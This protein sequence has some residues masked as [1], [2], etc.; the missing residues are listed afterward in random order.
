[1]F[2]HSD[3][4]T[5]NQDQNYI[6][7]TLNE[8]EEEQSQSLYNTQLQPHTVLLKD[9]ETTATMY[10]IPAYPELLPKGLLA[11]LL[12]EFN[13][14]IEK[15]DSFPYYDMLNL[16]EFEKVWFHEGG[17]VCIMVLGEIPELDYSLDD[18]ELSELDINKDNH[19]DEIETMR[20]TAQY[21]KRKERRNINLNIQWEKQCL[22]IFSLQPAYPGRSSHVVTGSFLVNAGI[23]GKGIGKTLVETFV[24]WSKRLGFTSCCFPLIYGTNVGIRRILEVLNF[25]RIGKL[26]E[27]GILKGF[28]VPVDSFIYGKE[29]THITKSID[30]L[31]DPQQ[32]NDIAKYERLRYYLETGKYPP[33]CD[34]NE[35]ARLRVSSKTHSLQNG[36]LTTKGREIIYEPEQQKQIALEMHIV[37]HQGINKITSRIVERYHWK[38]IK[39]T[40]S[41]VIAQCPKCK[42]RHQDGT[43]VIVMPSENVRQAH[44]LPQ[45]HGE[46]N[47]DTY[48]TSTLSQMAA[49]VVR[50]LQNDVENEEAEPTPPDITQAKGSIIVSSMN[51]DNS[52]ISSKDLNSDTSELTTTI[53]TSLSSEH[54]MNAFDRFVEEEQARKRRRYLTVA[55]DRGEASKMVVHTEDTTGEGNEEVPAIM[56]N[57]DE[58]M[59]NEAI[60]SLEKNVFEVVEMVENETRKRSNK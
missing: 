2:L 1:M 51:N 36:K 43:G 11:F 23:R 8:E 26:P 42:M 48:H 35:K 34:R 38:G 59:M 47:E 54:N 14:E 46:N 4:V 6:R 25:R 45:H 24:E 13:M 18:D 21:K 53:E 29:F 5:R 50:N 40:V 41:E 39:S 31:R 55:E 37:E 30:S 33:H 22:G 12:D 10:P 27:S 9:G 57:A 56:N 17:H 20:H 28:D 15:G 49:A 32:S 19:E 60:L 44:M 58:E 16:E 52:M 3:S 7:N